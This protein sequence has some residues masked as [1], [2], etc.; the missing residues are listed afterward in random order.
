MAKDSSKNW[1]RVYRDLLSEDLWTSEPFTTGQAWI[2][3]IGMAN[4]SDTERIHKG[5]LQSIKRGEIYTSIRY[6]AERWHWSKE[7]TARTLK[8][9]EKA[10]ML[11]INSN[12]NRTVLSLENY[13]KYHGGRDTKPTTNKDTT[14]P[15]TQDTTSPQKKK[16]KEGIKK[17]KEYHGAYGNVALSGGE[18][19]ELVSAFGEETLADLIEALSEYKEATGK[20]YK[21]DAAAIRTFARNRTPKREE[22]SFSKE[23]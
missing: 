17:G 11:T 6:L 22:S 14:S 21:N 7:K 15:T 20:N 13:D 23:Y 3:L 18:Y 9:F 4:Y 10:K 2:D 12:T 16:D 8:T 19:Q 5:R 1:F